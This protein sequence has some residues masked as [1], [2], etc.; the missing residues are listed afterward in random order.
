MWLKLDHKN[1]WGSCADLFENK[2]KRPFQ[3]LAFLQLK[4]NHTQS[5]KYLDI[6]RKN[7]V[8]IIFF[9]HP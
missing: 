1:R 7:I 4:Q 5:S 3:S 2:N 6:Q 9:I 8:E